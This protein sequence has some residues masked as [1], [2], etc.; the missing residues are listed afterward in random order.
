MNPYPKQELSLFAEEWY[1]YMSPATFNQLAI[2]AGV[3]KR[4]RK[5]HG[6]H[7]LSLC[8]CLTDTKMIRLVFI[9]NTQTLL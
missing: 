7:F 2:E 1:R 9:E 8:V 6:H 5:C 3:M 4:K